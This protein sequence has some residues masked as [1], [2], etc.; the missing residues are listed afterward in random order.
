MPKT[1]VHTHTHR[2]LTLISRMP[3]WIALCTCQQIW[4]PTNLHSCPHTHCTEAVYPSGGR[5]VGPCRPMSVLGEAKYF[6]CEGICSCQQS[7]RALGSDRQFSWGLWPREQQRR[8]RRGR[9]GGGIGCSQIWGTWWVSTPPRRQIAGGQDVTDE[10]VIACETGDPTS[11]H[12]IFTV[13]TVTVSFFLIK[14]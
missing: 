10:E 5:D 1:S 8:E 2:S 11:I 13:V 3:Q 4:T 12:T 9:T 7:D 6:H 14:L